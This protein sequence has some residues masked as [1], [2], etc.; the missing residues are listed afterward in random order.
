MSSDQSRGLSP[1]S[2]N[3][4]SPGRSLNLEQARKQAKELIR[5]FRKGD[6]KA[7]ARFQA[8]IT[9]LADKDS[10]KSSKAQK[11]A[12]HDAQRV[13]AREHGFESWQLLREQIHGETGFLPSDHEFVSALRERK[14]DQAR[15]LL[16]GDSS[17]VNRRVVGDVSMTGTVWADGEKVDVDPDDRR[18]VAAIHFAAFHGDADLARLLIEFSADIEQVVY[19]ENKG[20][21][22]A[23]V[24]AAWEGN[25]ETMQVL[26]DAGAQANVP[27]PLESPLYTAAS[28]GA[29]DKVRLLLRHGA[30]LDIFTAAMTGDSETVSRLLDEDSALVTQIHPKHGRT[31][32]Q[33]AL[34]C[35]Q[36]ETAK[37]LADRDSAVSPGA[38]AGL[39]RNEEIAQLLSREPDAINRQF[40]TQPLLTWALLGGQCETVKVLLDHGADPNGP[41]RWGVIPLRSV[42]AVRGNSGAEIV[43]LLVAAGADVNRLSREFTPLAAARHAGNDE[44]AKAL[45][46]HGAQHEL[47]RNSYYADWRNSDEHPFWLAVENNVV[48]SVDEYL[49]SD[50][51]LA[52]RDFRPEAKR[53]PH[54]H[55]RPLVAASAAGHFEIVQL[56]I[57][58][59]ADVDAKSPTE[60]Q[61]EFGMPLQLAVENGHYRVANLL[62]DHGASADCFPYCDQ[63]MTER[64]YELALQDGADKALA[65]RGFS[66][67]EFPNTAAP[68]V[69]KDAPITVKL[70]DRVL[71]LGGQLSV[72]AIVR[73]ENV[74]LIRELLTTCGRKTDPSVKNGETLFQ[75]IAG[76]SAWYGY[77]LI[78]QMCM[79]IHPDLYDVGCA[80]GAIRSAARSHNRDGSW[81]AYYRLIEYNLQLIKRAGQLD[82][83]RSDPE[84]KP[85]W[86]LAENYC[87]HSNYG[88]RAGVSTPEGLLAIAQLFLDWG[89]KD[90]TYRDPKSGLTVAEQSRERLEKGH[91]GMKEY[92]AFL[93]K[94]G[95][96]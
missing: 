33:E 82:E 72:A 93:K 23:L 87:W 96:E 38:A 29:R 19:E 59:G 9:K 81:Q 20:Q 65:Q 6:A 11:L 88:Y 26:L 54:T 36:P 76:A 57:D 71:S 43:D 34:S 50:S 4:Q 91:P 66:R 47:R 84:F 12:L 79:E 64:L 70:L 30:K 80:A 69:S 44:V 27:M 2:G 95:V 32:L 63:P 58:F 92:L 49:Q 1:D 7:I 37:I 18:S 86:L 52:D 55:R 21:T 28:H 3:S 41:D 77:P 22:T 62:L 83:L 68:T 13:V 40:G 48:A 51:T 67:Y 78:N 94:H 56:L 73:A 89:F 42:S 74:E 35:G 39:G 16:E 46:H 17:L 15:K 8:V 10:S 85:Q 31:A 75:R 60:D 14:L 90:L 61:R 25:L 24:L 45:E 53:D 5:G